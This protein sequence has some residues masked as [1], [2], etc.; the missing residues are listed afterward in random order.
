MVSVLVALCSVVLFG[1]VALAVD[2][3]RMYAERS[4]LQRTADV[5]ALSG[6]SAMAESPGAALPEARRYLLDNPTQYLSA[7]ASTVSL[8]SCSEGACVES[9]AVAPDF[10]FLFAGVLGFE[11]REISAQAKAVA[12]AGA[13][14]GLKLL[15]WGVLTCGTGPSPA[16]SCGSYAL[17]TSWSGPRIELSFG[18]T[19]RPPQEPG[20][21][22]QSTG[23]LVAVGVRAGTDCRTTAGTPAS[24]TGYFAALRGGRSLC[25]VGAGTQLKTLQPE[26]I[27]GGTPAALGARVRGCLSRSSFDRAVFLREG[28]ARIQDIDN[29]CLTAVVLVRPA[30]GGIAGEPP[31][32]VIATGSALFYVTRVG[33][34]NTYEGL[35]MRGLLTAS[36]D[37]DGRP[38]ASSD[39]LCVA[40]LVE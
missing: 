29:G 27:A 25:Y 13:P 36:A 30:A 35:L 24:S 28:F 15:P 32:R 33:P 14:G 22:E 18:D 34:D 10:P 5:S 1:F 3:A 20:G 8:A 9:R 2:M 37:D 40:K 16:G 12:A 19:S 39:F 23:N 17:A 38:C 31:S 11:N 4:E 6:A 26:V 21:P 7:G